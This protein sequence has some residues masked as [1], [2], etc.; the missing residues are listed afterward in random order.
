MKI[1]NCFLRQSSGGRR[2]TA[3][4]LIYSMIIL[5]LTVGT[6]SAQSDNDS[7]A[8]QQDDGQISQ[9]AAI[10]IQALIDEKDSRTPA[11]QKISS[12]LIYA[13]K[14]QKGEAI[15]TLA[16]TLSVDIETT[17]EGLVTVDIAAVVDKKLLSKLRE[18]GVKV[19]SSSVQYHTVRAEVSL[20]QLEGIANL[21]Q[22]KFIQP[23]RHATTNRLKNSGAVNR[24]SS[25]VNSLFSVN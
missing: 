5:T 7:A 12:Q 18:M 2:L 25:F 8:Q 24:P 19:I 13:A 1:K 23:K 15:S 21:P 20:N 10:R 3:L 11:Q 22:V 16:P 14:M 17:D 4:T 9:Q 6:T